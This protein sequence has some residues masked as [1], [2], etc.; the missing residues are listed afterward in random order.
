MLF[1][2]TWM[3]LKGIV[4]S[5]ISQT[6][7]EKYCMISVICGFYYNQLVTITTAKRSRPT[8]TE[9]S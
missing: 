1:A 9:R 3:D 4:L 2:T 7:R 6:E 8:D 5:E